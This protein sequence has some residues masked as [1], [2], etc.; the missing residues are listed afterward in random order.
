MKTPLIFRFLGVA[1][2]VVAMGG[3]SAQAVPLVSNLDATPEGAVEVTPGAGA[4]WAFQLGSTYTID[5]VSLKI[6]P[7]GGIGSLDDLSVELYTSASNTLPP[8]SSPVTTF[9]P[10]QAHALFAYDS[11][12]VAGPDDAVF[13]FVSGN[14]FVAADTWYWI[15]ASTSTGSYDWSFSSELG[16]GNLFYGYSTSDGGSSWTTIMDGGPFQAS[17]S[18]TAAVP[19]PSTYALLALGLISFFVLRRRMQQASLGSVLGV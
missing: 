7:T 16:S 1:A 8:D 9:V 11:L 14:N 19:E 10:D 4:A 2:L 17:V 3:A 12:A 6:I 13:N 15:V 18:G 5:S